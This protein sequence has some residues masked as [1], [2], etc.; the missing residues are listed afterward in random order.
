MGAA[1]PRP[2]LCP[3]LALT[4]AVSGLATPQDL[5]AVAQTQQSYLDSGG[6][7]LLAPSAHPRTRDAVAEHMERT[8]EGLTVGGE[9]IQMS[10]RS[11]PLLGVRKGSRVKCV[12]VGTLPERTALRTILSTTDP[13]DVEGALSELPP[14]QRIPLGAFLSAPGPWSKDIPPSALWVLWLV[15]Q[16]LPHFYQSYCISS[17]KTADVVSRVARS[18]GVGTLTPQHLEYLRRPMGKLS[19]EMLLTSPLFESPH[20]PMAVDVLIDQL[21]ESICDL[22]KTEWL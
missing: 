15:A 7:I 2:N 13:A 3:S 5:A 20:M 21:K 18:M 12:V 19:K 11:M 8:A 14:V 10:D 6:L 22:Q 4:R 17:R 16:R 1:L 9:V